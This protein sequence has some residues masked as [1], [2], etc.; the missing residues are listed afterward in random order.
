MKRG[1][2]VLLLVA[3]SLAITSCATG[4]GIELS[5]RDAAAL[6]AINKVAAA[7][8]G[9]DV[10]SVESTECW[11]PSLHLVDEDGGESTSTWRVLCRIHFVDDSGDR[12]K[13]TTCI[14]DYDAEPM[15]DQC[16]RWA[17]YTDEPRFEDYPGVVIP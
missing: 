12:Y 16:Y 8:S 9:V 4:P 11:L 13:D 10:D 17:P 5:A 1:L 2:T 6:A 14:G 3:A 7:T 15:L